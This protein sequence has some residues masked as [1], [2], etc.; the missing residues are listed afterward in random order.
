MPL[1]RYVKSVAIFSPTDLPARAGGIRGLIGKV[2]PNVFIVVGATFL[3]TVAYPFVTYQ[4]SNHR[5]QQGTLLSPVPEIEVIQ[6][7]GIVSPLSEPMAPP[8]L[9]A[10]NQQ[11]EIVGDVDLTKASN[12]FPSAPS[13]KTR[14]SK[15]SHYQLSIPKLKIDQAVVQIAGDS[16]N[17]H[18]IQY[19]GTALPGEYGNTVIF[20]HSVLPVFYNP[21]DY[22]SIFSL[23]PTLEKGDEIY[24]D[25]DG[26][27]YKYIIDSYSEVKPSEVEILEQ[28][29]DRQALTLIT[30]VPPGTYLKRGVILAYLSKL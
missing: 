10:Q 26:I 11:P 15:I 3:T 27:Q 18:L 13:T 22:M 20:G 4:L 5:W 23:L 8:V 7:K 16:L 2:L 17:K 9:A 12:W 1:Y 30:C 19:A 28:R 29:F 6:A 21:K 14:I 24:I 25:Y